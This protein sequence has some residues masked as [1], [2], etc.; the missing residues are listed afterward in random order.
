MKE[1]VLIT[2]GS[3][4]LGKTLALKL[5]DTH[6]VVLAARNHARNQDASALTG[7]AVAPLDVSNI[8][9]VR[10]VLHTYKPQTVIHAAA[11][12]FVDISERNPMECVD[13][14]VLGSENVI[15]ACVDLGVR[16]LVAV[17]TDKAA[18]PHGNIYGVSKA[19]ME[20]MCGLMDGRGGLRI[21]S[22]RFGNI[23]WST[24]SVFPIW[25]RMMETKG[26]IESTGPK[27]RRFFFTVDEA[28]DLV[29]R[30]WRHIEQTRGKILS[31]HMK[32]AQ[33]SD[34]LDVW[35]K[36]RGG[37]WKPIAP[38]PGDKDDEYLIGPSEPE[39]TSLVTFDG[40]PHYVIDFSNRSS[41]QLA[42]TI[43]SADVERLSADEIVTLLA[44]EPEEAAR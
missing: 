31:R 23:A 40:L 6:E 21:T 3:G 7:C 1:T 24:G 38:R 39:F 26:S 8:E 10:D 29:L 9:S 13:V 35:T 30:A 5:R 19:M 28:S 44:A 16:D 4:F 25:K 14:N 37:S 20:R 42:S 32:S 12:K 17:S 18:P 33:I 41:A 22:V 34:I 27:M 43:S 15:R 36:V 11:S 2:G